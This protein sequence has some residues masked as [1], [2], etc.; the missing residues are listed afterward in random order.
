MRDAEGMLDQLISFCGTKITETDAI[1]M[2]GITSTVQVSELAGAIIGSAPQQALK[3]LN[4]LSNSGKEMT[5][6]IADLLSYFRNLLILKVSNYDTSLIDATE[7]EVKTL[8][9][10]VRISHP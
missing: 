2:F 7:E 5:R 3:I 4:D 9:N 10:T 6:L 8:K 1:T